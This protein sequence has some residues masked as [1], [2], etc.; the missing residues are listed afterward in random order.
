[1]RATAVV[2]IEILAQGLPGDGY[3]MNK[4]NAILEQLGAPIP[5]LGNYNS[6]DEEILALEQ[7]VDR[8]VT[9]RTRER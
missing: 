3:Q 1:M 6:R 7:Q 4:A 5:R 2:E 8:I 9:E